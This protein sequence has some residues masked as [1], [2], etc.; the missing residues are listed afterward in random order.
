MLQDHARSCG[1]AREAQLLLAEFRADVCDDRICPKLDRLEQGQF[2]TKSGFAFH[3][4]HEIDWH[5]FGEI[6]NN[7]NHRM[8]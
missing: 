5:K 6:V 3:L 2:V 8:L 1:P 7:Q 4:L